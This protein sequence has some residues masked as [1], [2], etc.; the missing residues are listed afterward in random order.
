MGPL[1][2]LVCR[3]RVVVGGRPVVSRR[4]AVMRSKA[5]FHASLRA[6]VPS[7]H[8]SGPASPA[9]RK[10]ALVA[11]LPTILLAGLLTGCGS[12]GQPPTS[13]NSA[14]TRPS[15]STTVPA[16]S[17]ET[18]EFHS[19]AMG[20]SFRY[21]ASWKMLPGGPGRR[22][23]SGITFTGSTGGLQVF[24]L[25]SNGYAW[26]NTK[27]PLPF[28]GARP[29]DLRILVAQIAPPRIV[30]S[31]ITHLDGLRVAALEF[32]ADNPSGA[33]LSGPVHEILSSSAQKGVSRSEIRIAVFCRAEQWGDSQA[34]LLAV[35]ASVRLSRPAG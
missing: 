23:G 28:A 17:V 34:T 26:G 6:D 24:V 30:R 35:L 9:V 8:A 22:T 12:S 4:R 19:T 29:S 31:Q 5:T 25:Y 27:T 11:L 20:I 18:R 10:V 33:P 16:G 1:L 3:E 2:L 21:P 13:G 15:T 32:L 7:G 14:S